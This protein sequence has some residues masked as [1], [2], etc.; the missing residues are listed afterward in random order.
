MCFF[1]S[2]TLSQC[3]DPSTFKEIDGCS[4][5]GY[6]S[7]VYGYMNSHADLQQ[8]VLESLINDNDSNDTDINDTFYNLDVSIGIGLLNIHTLSQ[9]N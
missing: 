5:R 7:S 8:N 9:D 4:E 2:H 1:L 6:V 3:E